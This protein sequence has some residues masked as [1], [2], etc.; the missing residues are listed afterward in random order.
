VR[1]AEDEVAGD[2]VLSE[3]FGSHT[4]F[5]STDFPIFLSFIG[6]GIAQSA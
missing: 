2:L 4:T 1:L 6:A 3:Y 5:Y